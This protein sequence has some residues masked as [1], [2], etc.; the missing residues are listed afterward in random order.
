MV[1]FKEWLALN[2]IV[3]LCNHCDDTANV[4]TLG[5]QTNHFY[6]VF[7]IE[8]K[9][10]VV[11]AL[12]Y[13]VRYKHPSHLLLILQVMYFF[14][15]M[16][17]SEKMTSNSGR[18][19]LSCHHTLFLIRRL[20]EA[21]WTRLFLLQYSLS[22]AESVRKTQIHFKESGTVKCNQKDHLVHRFWF[23]RYLNQCSAEFKRSH[24]QLIL[25]RL[26]R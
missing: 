20:L 5:F 17:F 13:Q 6:Q 19:F 3:W 16:L 14:W 7:F 11:Q 12:V 10:W 1:G 22:Q 15:N 4:Q 2:I 24:Q 18:H 8:T 9:I 26:Y 23:A 21:T 25:D